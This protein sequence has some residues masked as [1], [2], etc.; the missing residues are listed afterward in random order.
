MLGRVLSGPA[1]P[2]LHPETS[3]RGL[4]TIQEET[5]QELTITLPD[6]NVKYLES[7]SEYTAESVSEIIEGLVYN[8]FIRHFEIDPC[9]RPRSGNQLG[10][11]FADPAAESEFLNNQLR[12]WPENSTESQ[13][14]HS[15]LNVLGG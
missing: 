4:Q 1:F 9:P 7:M 6:H 15:R 13:M 3:V 11:P 5:M 12:H 8:H 2:A 10:K 14:I